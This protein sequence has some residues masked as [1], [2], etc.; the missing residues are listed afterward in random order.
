MAQPSY[1]F[2]CETSCRKQPEQRESHIPQGNR[3]SLARVIPDP[4]Q[5]RCTKTKPHTV[6]FVSAYFLGVSAYV[7]GGLFAPAPRMTLHALQRYVSKGDTRGITTDNVPGIRYDDLSQ[8]SLS[9]GKRTSTARQRRPRPFSKCLRHHQAHYN[10]DF[11]PPPL[12]I[13]LKHTKCLQND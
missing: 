11:P 6:A 9:A 1:S 3:G 8:S 12:R 10:I 7:H 2:P 13:R 5:S 4:P